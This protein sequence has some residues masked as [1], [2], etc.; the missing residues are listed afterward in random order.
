ML[1][2]QRDVLAD[3]FFLLIGHRAKRRKNAHDPDYS[4]D[5]DDYSSSDANCDV[6]AADAYTDIT[7]KNIIAEDGNTLDLKFDYLDPNTDA[8]PPY[9]LNNIE[10]DM[11]D[12]DCGCVHHYYYRWAFLIWPK[13]NDIPVRLKLCGEDYA[14]S[15]LRKAIKSH[16]EKKRPE[17]KHALYLALRRLDKT[18]DMYNSLCLA[19]VVLEDKGLLEQY[20]DIGMSW[21]VNVENSTLTQAVNAFGW[22]EAESIIE[23]FLSDLP[24]ESIVD[25]FKSLMKAIHAS[26]SSLGE[27]FEDW[28]NRQRQKGEFAG[29]STLI[30]LISD[31]SRPIFDT[32]FPVSRDR[33]F[34]FLFSLCA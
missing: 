5:L 1:Y 25:R 30:K 27:D 32:Y 34:S 9:T 24:K 2:A 19:A 20:I 21:K 28:E 10:P 33:R 7:T 4:T 23:D 3:H 12:A 8:T 29:T 31:F 11:K 14:K 22:E 18:E 15:Y 16:T 26:P 13:A 17:T 6:I